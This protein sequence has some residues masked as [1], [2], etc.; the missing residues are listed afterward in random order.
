M[1]I[2]R[3]NSHHRCVQVYLI[4]VGCWALILVDRA[5]LSLLTLPN[6]V[7][8]LLLFLAVALCHTTWFDHGAQ[9]IWHFLLL[10]SHV[11]SRSLFSLTV[12]AH[13][14]ARLKELLRRQI[15]MRPRTARLGLNEL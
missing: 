1:A 6:N 15:Y 3:A 8:E 11:I 10:I 2:T 5:L 7:D 4:A 9:V 13:L 14:H 12:R